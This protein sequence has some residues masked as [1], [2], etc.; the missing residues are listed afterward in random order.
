MEMVRKLKPG[1]QMLK[2]T[3]I[4]D[5]PTM[6]SLLT[7]LLNME[8]YIVR[9]PSNYEMKVMLNAILL[10]RPQIVLVDANL[11]NGSGLDLVRSIRREAELKGTCIIMTSGLNLR[12]ESLKVGA[13]EFIQKPFMPD[14][15]I[16]RI[17]DTYQLSNKYQLQKE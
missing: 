2:V 5:D 12:E 17:Q 1:H 16:K 15:L 10:E 6:I 13:D 11:A 14:D 4:E 8:G 3:L 9:I 7:T